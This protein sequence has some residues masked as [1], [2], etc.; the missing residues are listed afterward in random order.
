MMLSGRTISRFIGLFGSVEGAQGSP[1]T[2]DSDLSVKAASPWLC[3]DA[4][5]SRLAC[6]AMSILLILGFR[7]FPEIFPPVVR[8]NPIS[9]FSFGIRP[10]SD[11]VQERQSVFV[12]A[13]AIDGDVPVSMGVDCPGSRSSRLAPMPESSCPNTGIRVV[14]QN[15]LKSLLSEHCSSHLKYARG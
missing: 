7:R 14:V 11:H 3:V 6:S 4:A 2:V 10:S 8:F 13:S 15:F 5:I 12:M 1:L 9:V